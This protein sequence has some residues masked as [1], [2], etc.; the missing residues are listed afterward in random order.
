MTTSPTPDQINVHIGNRIKKKR[1]MLSSTL[2]DLGKAI[3]VSFQQVQ[4][5]ERGM[6]SVSCSRLYSLANALGEDVSYFFADISKSSANV[7][8]SDGK[9]VDTNDKDMLSL[10][11]HFCTLKDE[12]VR[13]KVLD[14]VRALSE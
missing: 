4:K 5:Y 6:N 10:M 8:P 12:N 3:G 14:L 11:K 1:L 2:D 13:R 7:I 9:L